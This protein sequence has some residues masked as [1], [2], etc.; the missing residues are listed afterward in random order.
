MNEHNDRPMIVVGYTVPMQHGLDELRP[1][2]SVMFVD[3]PDVAIGRGVETHLGDSTSVRELI[4]F[5]YQRPG[6]ADAFFL[7]HPDLRPSAVLPGVEYA[8]PFAARLAERY[9]V[10]GAGFG[11]AQILRD[12]ALL[13]TVTRAAGVA[14]PRSEAVDGP[15]A[16]RAFM[17]EQG[18]AV[19]LKPANRQASVGTKILFDPAE[20]DQAWTEC[21]QQDEGVFVPG[22]GMPLRMLVEQYVEGDEYSV[23][24]VVRD[25]ERLFGNVTAKTVY[26]GPRPVELGHTVPADLPAAQTERLLAETGRVLAAAGFGTGFVHCEW[27]VSGGTPYLVECAGR[28]PGDGIME[29][30]QKA[31]RFDV[32]GLY[33]AAMEDRTFTG[34]V[35]EQAPAGAAVWFLHVEPGEVLS[36]DGAEAAKAV[37]DVVTVVVGP[38]PGD[39][40][41]ELRSSWDRV[42]LV[43]ACSVDTAEAL[44]RAQQAIGEITI[45][46]APDATAVE[47]ELAVA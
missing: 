28:M 38:K 26:P 33:L 5:E 25:G 27:I 14:N 12:K 23:E 46:V 39:R 43:T 11:A 35:P 3:E 29:L 21:T 9:G 13:R 7:R 37:P 17:A 6:A 16:V 10:P 8:V 36:V 42:A 32:V 22:R 20:I 18:G 47:R 1:P 4:A 15:D 19:I 34:E 40:V 41:N 31:W 45:T 24:M 44:R 30:I 2:D